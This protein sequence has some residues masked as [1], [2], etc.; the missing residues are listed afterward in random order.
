MPSDLAVLPLLVS[1]Q[2]SSA[3]LTPATLLRLKE[4]YQQA[5][6]A[7]S[8]CHG[9]QSC[10][11]QRDC[12]YHAAVGQQLS[13]DPDL[14]RRHQK[15]PLP[16][17][18]QAVLKSKG[19]LPGAICFQL[20]LIGRV[21]GHLVS[22]VTALKMA[23]AR[24]Q[25]GLLGDLSLTGIAVKGLGGELTWLPL[26]ASA[27]LPDIPCL[28]WQDWL[29]QGDEIVNHVR[30]ELL[31]P[32]RLLKDGRPV[33]RFEPSLFLRQLVRRSSALAA[34]YGDTQLSADFR[35]LA[36]LSQEVTLVHGDVRWERQSGSAQ[37][38]VGWV[39]LVGPLADFWSYLRLGEFVNLGKGAAF[40]Q[41]QYRMTW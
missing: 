1:L 24:N 21:A 5:L 41:G 15:P 14:V 17:I 36:E 37:G 12:P 26:D 31:T 33:G 34:Y 18:Y 13:C 11:Q 6:A 23:F 38:L 25:S 10:D 30:I 4:P 27:K 39:E 28:T 40:G 29:L 22:H 20:N 2:G 35:H 3:P 32:L 9:A 19:N 16:F 7:L 8:A